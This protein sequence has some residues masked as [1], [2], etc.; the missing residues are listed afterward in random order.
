MCLPG[1]AKTLLTHVDCVNMTK[2]LNRMR[3]RTTVL[4]F[5]H[6]TLVNFLKLV[7]IEK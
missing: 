6:V 2:T 3:R 7:V 5:E 4:L 1:E